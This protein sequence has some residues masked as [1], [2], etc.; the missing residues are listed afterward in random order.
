MEKRNTKTNSSLLFRRE[1]ITTCN[2]TKTKK[3]KE[4]IS[5]SRYYSFFLPEST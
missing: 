3:K 2:D 5:I 1:E 4:K